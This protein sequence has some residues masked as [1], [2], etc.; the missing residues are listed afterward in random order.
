RPADRAASRT[1]TRKLTYAE[2]IE[3]GALP[4][5]ID[6]LE[7]EQR[8]LHERMA[9]PAFYR[10]AGDEIAAARARL[11]ALETELALAYER[12]EVLAARAE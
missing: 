10:S 4:D 1:A 8:E 12:W 11:D 9:D 6:A 5:R 3:L 7:R 2:S